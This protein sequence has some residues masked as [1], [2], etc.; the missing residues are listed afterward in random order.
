MRSTAS[1]GIRRARPTG[2]SAESRPT[3]TCVSK[4]VACSA[5]RIRSLSARK[6][7]PPPFTMPFTAVITGFQQRLWI[8]V[9][10]ISGESS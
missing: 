7:S 4:N 1:I 2:S 6:C 5:A 10:L 3:F 8:A 9:S